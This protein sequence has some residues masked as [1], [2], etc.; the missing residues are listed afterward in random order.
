MRV[1]LITSKYKDKENIMSAAWCF[2]L[3]ADPP[4]FGV[5]LSK[6]RY[7]YELIH[8][9][10][11]FAINIPGEELKGAV[12]LCGR[13]SMREKNKFELTKLTKENGKLGAPL[14]KECNASIECIVIDE[15]GIGD[16]VLF[17]GEVKNVVKRREEKG[18]YHR[19]GDDFTIV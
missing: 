4:L 3:S 16:H 5:C 12:L 19:G 15:K 1:V 6:K 18:L 2:P 8:Q 9:S 11:Q 13:T 10:R 14:I 7:S 17:V